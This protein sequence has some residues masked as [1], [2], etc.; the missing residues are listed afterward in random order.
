MP[1]SPSSFLK[2]PSSNLISPSLSLLPPSSV[3]RTGY[4]TQKVLKIAWFP[5]KYLQAPPA[6]LAA[7]PRSVDR[8]DF[9]GQVAGWLGGWLRKAENKAKAQQSWGLGFAELGN[10][11]VWIRQLCQ[12]RSVRGRGHC[13]CARNWPQSSLVPGMQN[14]QCQNQLR[15]AHL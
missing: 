10:F 5:T 7:F 1:H 8:Q 12:W 11:Q 2:P 15:A 4:L 3:K 13:A 6:T 9:P 14:R